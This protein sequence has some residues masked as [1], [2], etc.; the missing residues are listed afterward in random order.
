[1]NKGNTGYFQK[2]TLVDI[3]NNPK[4]RSKI[5]LVNYTEKVLDNGKLQKRTK[6]QTVATFVFNTAKA[7]ARPYYKPL[8]AHKAANI[9]TI[10]GNLIGDYNEAVD[11]I[12]LDLLH[13]KHILRYT[14]NNADMIRSALKEGEKL[15]RSGGKSPR[16]F[17]RV[18]SMYEIEHMSKPQIQALM[19]DIMQNIF[20][21]DEFQETQKKYSVPEIAIN[22]PY[23]YETRRQKWKRKVGDL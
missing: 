20:Y 22:S 23:D 1:M 7:S 11:R 8:N 15:R 18:S 14:A 9:I 3:F 19:N 6:M 4:L 13:N 2:F 21:L 17:L 12:Y 5:P 10:D 16:L